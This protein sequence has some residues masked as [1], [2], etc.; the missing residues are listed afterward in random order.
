M[1]SRRMGWGYHVDVSLVRPTHNINVLVLR[2]DAKKENQQ[3]YLSGIKD[4]LNTIKIN[5][6]TAVKDEGKRQEAVL[7]SVIDRFSWIVN[8]IKNYGAMMDAD[9]IREM[10][11]K[12]KPKD[13]DNLIDETLSIEP[14][15]I[16]T[17]DLD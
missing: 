2:I 7:I 13:L 3:E 14:T 17:G 1:Y 4:V 15:V 16:I 9:K 5:T 10:M 6:E 8:G 11:L 12:V